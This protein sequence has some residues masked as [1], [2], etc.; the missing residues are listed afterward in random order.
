MIYY[1]DT[2]F[3]F[4]YL[5]D[6]VFFTLQESIV[7]MAPYVHLILHCTYFFIL[8]IFGYDPSHRSHTSCGIAL[9]IKAWSVTLRPSKRR[10]DEG[11]YSHMS[12]RSCI[13]VEPAFCGNGDNSSQIIGRTNAYTV[14]HMTGRQS[15]PKSPCF[16]LDFPQDLCE[17]LS[18]KVCGG[19]L[20]PFAAR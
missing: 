15:S 13:W 9:W 18:F 6:M 14:S 1:H 7:L 10:R 20:H 5:C 16:S 4:T 12:F 3:L 11:A 8:C 2:P 19:V 17:L